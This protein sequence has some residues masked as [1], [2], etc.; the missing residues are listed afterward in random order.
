MIQEHPWSGTSDRAATAQPG[1]RGSWLVAELVS[2][3]FL[4]LADCRSVCW[5]ESVQDAGAMFFQVW[6]I[7]DPLD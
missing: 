2:E 5:S 4:V 1:G 6:E 3:V 7:L